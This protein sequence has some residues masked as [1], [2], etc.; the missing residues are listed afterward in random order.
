MDVEV[1]VSIHKRRLK[2]TF[3]DSATY[4]FNL[5]IDGA[6]VWNLH[7]D[8]ARV[9]Q[10]V[11]LGRRQDACAYGIRLDGETRARIEAE[12]AEISEHLGMAGFLPGRPARRK[13]GAARKDAPG[14]S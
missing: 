3:D 4:F 9:L 12:E 2:V 10:N 8:I 14:R 7:R 11:F 5:E 6:T 13:R 1:K